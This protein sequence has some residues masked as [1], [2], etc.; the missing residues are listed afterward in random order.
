MRLSSRL[1][2]ALPL[3]A[4][5]GA[6]RP[7]ESRDPDLGRMPEWDLRDLYAAPEAPDVASDVARAA[8]EAGRIKAAYQGK[9]T[10]LAASGAALAD[11]VK[12]YERLSD[13]IGKLGSYAGLLYAANTADPARAKF[14]GDIQE[15]ITAMTTDLIFFELEMNQIDDA[16]LAAGARGS[17]PR[18]LQALVRRSAQRKSLSAR[19]KARAAVPRKIRDLA[20][21]VEPAVQRDDDGAALRGRRRAR[22]DRARADAQH[23]DQRRRAK[24]GRRRPKRWQRC[25]R[26]TSACSR[27]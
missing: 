2:G 27:C 11:A 7:G 24:S 14:Y 18:P 23:A 25:S 9:L 12:A 21:L 16:T 15:K 19:G 1:P 10:A 13:L 26:T 22:A 3:A 8:A 5:L 17:R 4:S 20:R 6:T